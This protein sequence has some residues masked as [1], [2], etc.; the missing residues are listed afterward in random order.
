MSYTGYM[1]YMSIKVV[2]LGLAVDVPLDKAVVHF[3]CRS[4]RFLLPGFWLQ[5]E[6]DGLDQ[7]SVGIEDLGFN[8]TGFRVPIQNAN[9][10]SSTL[11]YGDS[12][13]VVGLVSF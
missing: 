13:I 6:S 10:G 11:V 8:R 1:S 3:R 4:D 9:V 7:R 2:R 5:L 12:N